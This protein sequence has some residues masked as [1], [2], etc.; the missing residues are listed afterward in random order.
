MTILCTEPD[1]LRFC[2]RLSADV[3]HGPL[4]LARAMVTGR[5]VY[6]YH[7]AV[8]GN[9][10]MLLRCEFRSRDVSATVTDR[11]VTELLGRLTTYQVID[12]HFVDQDGSVLDRAKLPVL[13]GS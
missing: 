8:L 7:D 9:A 10:D 1:D 13:V 2:R 6:P 12:A 11:Q 5:Q 3:N 4:Y